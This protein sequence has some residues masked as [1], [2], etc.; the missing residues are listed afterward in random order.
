M[1]VRTYFVKLVI[2]WKKSLKT[3]SPWKGHLWMFFGNLNGTRWYVQMVL[4]D[5]C[6]KIK[7]SRWRWPGYCGIALK[8]LINW[9]NDC[10]KWSLHL[11]AVC[12][13][14]NHQ[15]NL[16]RGAL[17]FL[18]IERW[19]LYLIRKGC[20][21]IVTNTNTYLMICTPSSLQFCRK[22]RNKDCIQTWKCKF[23]RAEEIY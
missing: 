3:K 12:V 17:A 5:F 4:S 20:I 19:T 6:E 7:I 1:G 10:G 11:Y 8:W 9:N 13:G 21:S 18:L 16:M 2:F 22:K 14:Q 15:L 23:C